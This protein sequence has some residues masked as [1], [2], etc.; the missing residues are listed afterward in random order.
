MEA[1]K[2][3]G[4]GGTAD[5]EGKGNRRGGEGAGGRTKNETSWGGGGGGV[6]KTIQRNPGRKKTLQYNRV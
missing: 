2:N 1:G 4:G 6:G 3:W 5:M